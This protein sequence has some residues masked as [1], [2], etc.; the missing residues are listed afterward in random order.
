M[1]VVMSHSWRWCKELHLSN[2]V[3]WSLSF[4][5]LSFWPL[6]SFKKTVEDWLTFPKS[7][8]KF[9]TTSRDVTSP[10]QQACRQPLLLLVDLTPSHPFHRAKLSLPEKTVSLWSWV[11]RPQELEHLTNPLYE[12]NSLVIWPSVA[13]QSLLLWEGK[14]HTRHTVAEISYSRCSK[15][16]CLLERR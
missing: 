6:S 5:F 10:F 8:L 7:L 2:N 13:P 9:S 11:N 14:K 15:R 4:T 1:S 16:F 12:A 3:L